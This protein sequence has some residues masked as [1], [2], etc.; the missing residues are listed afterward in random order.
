MWRFSGA[1]LGAACLLSVQGWAA[2]KVLSPLSSDGFTSLR[3]GIEVGAAGNQI[4]DAD[5]DVRRDHV[6]LRLK[7]ANNQEADLMLISRSADKQVPSSRYFAIEKGDSAA[8]LDLKP[9]E[10][11]LDVA[12]PSDPWVDAPAGVRTPPPSA[13]P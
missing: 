13:S 1:V 2:E 9:L 3:D 10:R 4:K 12:F 5:I 11:L 7:L 6:I 8:G